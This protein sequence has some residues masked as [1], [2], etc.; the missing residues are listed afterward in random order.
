MLLR[1][2]EQAWSISEL[3]YRAVLVTAPGWRSRFIHIRRIGKILSVLNADEE[4][5]AVE[6]LL[7]QHGAH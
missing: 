1:I 7:Q 6:Q 5:I 2:P 4:G 3:A